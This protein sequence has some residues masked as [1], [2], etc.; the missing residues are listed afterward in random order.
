MSRR[1][2]KSCEIETFSPSQLRFNNKKKITFTYVKILP[3]FQII[4]RTRLIRECWKQ[5][6]ALFECQNFWFKFKKKKWLSDAPISHSK[7]RVST[8]KQLDQA[9]KCLQLLLFSP[10]E[11]QQVAGHL[12]R[13]L[14]KLVRKVWRHKSEEWNRKRETLSGYIFTSDQGGG[15]EKMKE[16]EKK[17]KSNDGRRGRRRKAAMG[18]DNS[19]SASEF[20]PPGILLLWSCQGI[21]VGTTWHSR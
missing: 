16:K 1:R 15:W 11:T 19:F 5:K 10:A 21:M 7:P 18:T 12:W 8:Q 9:M 3:Q 20:L 2:R 4:C 13:N 6:K 14:A 17:W